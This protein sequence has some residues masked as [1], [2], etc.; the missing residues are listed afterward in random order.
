MILQAHFTVVHSLECFGKQQLR[1]RKLQVRREPRKAPLPL[2][3]QLRVKL[4][5]S[6]VRKATLQVK[7]AILVA[8]EKSRPE[9]KFRGGVNN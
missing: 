7:A 2:R 4:R 1:R 6:V 9:P 3:K 8:K 5:R